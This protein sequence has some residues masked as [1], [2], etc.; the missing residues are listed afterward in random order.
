M[1]CYKKPKI[2]KYNFYDLKIKKIRKWSKGYILYKVWGLKC[3]HDPCLG[4]NKP[5]PF[6]TWKGRVDN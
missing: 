2:I 3:F 1:H 6:L 5:T 4:K